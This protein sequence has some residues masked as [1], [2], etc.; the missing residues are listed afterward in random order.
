MGGREYLQVLDDTKDHWAGRTADF[1]FMTA[2]ETS[3]G[4]DRWRQDLLRVIRAY[5]AAHE[6][7]LKELEGAP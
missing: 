7:P 1:R 4:L 5:A 2:P 3:I 6:L